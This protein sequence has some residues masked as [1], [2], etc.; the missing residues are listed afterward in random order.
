MKALLLLYFLTTSLAALLGIDIGQDFTKAALVAPR[1]PFEIV[2]SSDSKR[3]DVSGLAL[4]PLGDG[5]ER[6]YGSQTS[7]H[8]TRFPKQCILNTK[9]LLGKPADDQV[10]Q[11]YLQSHPGVDIVPSKNNRNTISF[12][13]EEAQYPIEEALAM[14][15][16]DIVSRASEL[17]KEKAPGGYYPQIRD[18]AIT[19][20]TF[21][22]M[23]QRNALKDAAELAGLNVVALI[24][25]GLAIATNYAANRE[26]DV[27]TEYHVI[28]DMGAGSTKATLVSFTNAN[29]SVPLQMN[30]EGYGYD[31]TLGGA[32]FTNGVAEL[33]KAKFLESH[34]NIRSARF[35]S[36]ERA[37]AKLFQTAEKAKLVLSANNEAPISIESFFD[38]IDFKTKITREEFEE[39]V[40][41]VS[42]R[43]TNPLL[44]ALKEAGLTVDNLTS[45]LY[46]G[47]STRVPFVQRHLLSLIGEQLVSKTI[48]ADEAA[49]FGTSLRGV[50]ISNMFRAKELNIT[51]QSHYNYRLSFEDDSE[52]VIFPKGSAYGSTEVVDLSEKFTSSED[53]SFDV[54][55]DA[56]RYLTYH[57][58]KP[59]EIIEKLSLNTSEC[60]DDVKY[61]A[62]FTLTESR[63][64][65]LDSFKAEC[66]ASKAG[67]LEKL[68]S[69]I[70]SSDE[71]PIVKK[72]SSKIATKPKYLGSRPLGT[73]SKQELRNHLSLLDAKDS[74]RKLV[75]EKLNELE[76]ALYGS[77][78][79]FTNDGVVEKLPESM[80]EEANEVISEYLEWLDFESDGAALKEIKSKLSTVKKLKSQGETY[81]AQ[82]SIP[83]DVDAFKEL[84]TAAVESVNSFQNVLMTS[85][86]EALNVS[87][88]FEEVGLDYEQEVKK[89]KKAMLVSEEDIDKAKQ[90]LDKIMDQIKQLYE[91]PTELDDLEREEKLILQKEANEKIDQVEKLKKNM[92]VMHA[93]RMKGLKD[94]YNK[95]LRALKRAASKQEAAAKKEGEKIIAESQTTEEEDEEYRDAVEHDE[96]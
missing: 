77:R 19:V 35:Q 29:D 92:K 51:E 44:D 11:H 33:V 52:I 95:H 68:K 89:L 66:S 53:F 94:V 32:Y 41:D 3:K 81:I 70:D 7:S 30:V 43:I 79:Y 6:L 31:E 57:V 72:T 13:I 2:M 96:L 37:V 69:K 62:S 8:C 4:K 54:I 93:Q 36:N 42:I 40:S 73:A 90:E 15:I 60:I 34:P 12:N 55:E 91:N 83:L 9:A 1:M 82:L 18:V 63:L 61:L 88:K 78:T 21:F 10:V 20:P 14:N 49:V 5:V 17:L 71:K 65:V 23:A 85:V 16:Q 48:N 47:G 80:V 46:A 75:S 39:F 27:G 74:Q 87:S 67:F 24:D 26:F 56:K 22:Q 50:Q 58:G 59:S 28:Y 76:A 64:L 86:E 25:D 84:Y 45:V 38:E